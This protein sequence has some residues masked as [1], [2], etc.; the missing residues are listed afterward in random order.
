MALR[1]EKGWKNELI[2]AGAIAF[3]VAL[4]LLHAADVIH[5]RSRR[6]GTMH[7][8]A[9]VLMLGLATVVPFLLKWWD[10][11]TLVE[12]DE[13]DVIFFVGRDRMERCRIPRSALLLVSVQ[14]GDDTRVLSLLFDADAVR[15]LRQFTW[16]PYL[17]IKGQEVV[18]STGYVRGNAEQVADAWN[19]AIQARSQSMGLR[20]GAKDA[21][22]LPG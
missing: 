17:E 14:E 22:R 8:M 16:T 9:I 11:G 5:I 18:I 4:L 1:I 7:F 15:P 10:A 13:K 6:G 3:L 20:E 19:R 2:I 21:N 12:M